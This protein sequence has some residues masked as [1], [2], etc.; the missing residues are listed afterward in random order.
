MGT[1]EGG[2][3]RYANARLSVTVLVF[4]VWGKNIATPGCYTYLS[5]VLDH[6]PDFAVTCSQDLLGKVSGGR[7][8][9]GSLG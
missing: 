8:C 2:R 4:Y 9:P 6:T 1:S 7:G 5:D 3:W